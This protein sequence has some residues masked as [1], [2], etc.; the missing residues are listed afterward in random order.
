MAILVDTGVLYALA[1]AD[2]GW[3]ERS[4]RW[5]EDLREL[6]LAPVTVLPEVAYLLQTRLGSAVER[7]FVRSLATG[8][9]DVEPLESTDIQRAF[10]LTRRY[11]D[12]GF[13]DLSMVAMAERLKVTTLATTDRR[14]LSRVTPKHVA[15]FT[16]VP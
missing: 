11:P 7:R 2:D 15:S 5:L 13:V 6:V 9:L 16:L 4:R 10:E 8:E 3:H 1:D 14:H 12:L